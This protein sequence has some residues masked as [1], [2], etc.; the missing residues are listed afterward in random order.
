[1]WAILALIAFLAGQVYL[2]RSL[3][4]VDSLLARQEEPEEKEVLSLAFAD[5][6]AAEQMARLLAEFSR[7]NPDVEMV[8][9][10]DPAVQEAVY[11]GRAAVGF[12]P[13]NGRSL[14]GLSS[15]AVELAGLAAQQVI[16]KTGLQSDCAA[17]FLRYLRQSGGNSL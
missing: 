2:F 5:P 6:A 10:T 14:H 13:G 4:K 8:L 11:E 1:M 7:E 12:L 9:H 3:G 16:W 15:C 17:A